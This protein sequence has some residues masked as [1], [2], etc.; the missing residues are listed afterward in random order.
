MVALFGF[1]MLQPIAV[2]ASFKPREVWQRIEWEEHEARREVTYDSDGRGDVISQ[3]RLRRWGT[4]CRAAKL[5]VAVASCARLG[6]RPVPRLLADYLE[7]YPQALIRGKRR[8]QAMGRKTFQ[9]IANALIVVVGC[10]SASRFY[11]LDSTASPTGRALTHV[12]VAVG[13]VSVPTSVDQRQFVLQVAANRV[14]V[15]EFN[16]WPRR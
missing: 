6:G 4:V 7:R 13:P 12:A 1:L 2:Q 5:R 15:E 16:R 9:L 14:D 10:T 11:A 8:G 3:P